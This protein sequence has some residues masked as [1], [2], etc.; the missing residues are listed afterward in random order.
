M[1][2]EILQFPEKT[3]ADALKNLHR[4]GDSFEIIRYDAQLALWTLTPSGASWQDFIL[5]SRKFSAHGRAMYRALTDGAREWV[6]ANEPLR[7]FEADSWSTLLEKDLLNAFQSAYLEMQE[8]ALDQARVR[9]KNEKVL[10][11][12]GCVP[13]LPH[14]LRASLFSH[15]SAHHY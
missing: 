14:S 8:A 9:A 7:R 10:A 13:S 12:R 15:S 1:C 3:A 6:P 4:T 11:L 5:P 2:D